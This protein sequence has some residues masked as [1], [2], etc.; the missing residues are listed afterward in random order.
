MTARSKNAAHPAASVAEP[1]LTADDLAGEV[2]RL[3]KVIVALMD[4]AERSL[5]HQG[6][7]F[8]LFQ[9]AL[10]LEDEVQERTQQLAH[11]LTENEQ[12][13][14]SLYRLTASLKD[15]IQQRKRAE[16]LRSG[17]YDILEMITANA[18]LSQVLLQLTRWVEKQGVIGTASVLLLDDDGETIGESFASSLPEA[19]SQ[20]LLGVKI[21]PAAGACGTAM[22]RKEAVIVHDIEVDPLWTEYRA[23]AAEF[24]LRAC[25]SNPI[26]TTQGQVMGSFAIY[27]KTPRSPTAEQ[28]DLIAGAVH[29]AG[30]A[31]ERA[32]TE[33][34]IHY[35]A[36]HDD[37][38]GLPNRVLLEDRIN[39]AIEQAGRRHGRTAVLMIDL[40]RFK[41]VNDSLGHHVGD[42][43]LKEVAERLQ[44]CVRASDTIARLGGDEFVINIPDAAANYSASTVATNILAQLETPF[45]IR[46]RLLQLGASIGI[47]VYPDDGK[48]AQDLLRAADTA[49][50][51]AKK[52]GR[53][54][55]HCFTHELNQAAH[56]HIHLLSQLQSAIR[57]EEFRLVYQPLY[58]LADNRLIGAEALLRWQ[59]P[60]RG[61]LAPDQFL[62]LLEEH[63]LMV[64]VGAWVLRSACAQAAKWHRQGASNFRVSVNVAADQFHRGNLVRTVDEALKEAKLAPEFLMLEFTETVLLKHSDNL[65]ASMKQ[66]KQL[67]VNLSLDDFGTGYSSLSY[68]HRYPVDELKIDRSFVQG[69]HEQTSALNIVNSI[70]GL[71]NSL[72]I[73]SVAEGIET[74]VQRAAVINLACQYGQGYLFGRPL[75]AKAFAELLSGE[76]R[77]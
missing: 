67:G 54:Q 3:N 72:G 4:R 9:T 69:L 15:E 25:W 22:Y 26:I 23:L 53:N 59:H 60:E 16:S 20:A 14:Q 36:H 21:G 55:Y 74:E 5:A 61:L 76:R 28:Q 27:Y 77:R 49:M 48:N 62:Y 11:A 29:L 41:H 66:L 44:A 68:L 58:R 7:A 63:G 45:F 6:S 75:A 1:T 34:R 51:A 57:N 73:Q 64:D 30:I 40:D 56:D 13:T 47:S 10:T 65:M 38:T 39:T 32:R 24:G 12:I 2:S 52:S 71:A 43:I 33:A 31:I 35:M 17:Q 42:L 50:Y 70:V 18:P 19:Y 8:D 37:L 46:N